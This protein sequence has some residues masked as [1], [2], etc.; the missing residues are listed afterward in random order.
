M[1]TAF[2]FPGQG[3][4]YV[5]MGL[6]W[7]RASSEAR[8][9]CDRADASLSYALTELCFSGPETQLNQTE[10]T[11]PALFVIALAMWQAAKPILPPPAFVVG[12]S[13]GEF[14]ALVAAGALDFDA[15]LHLVAERGRLMARAGEK[16][17]GGMAVLL[18]ATL[19]AA[20]SLCDA[21][22]T[23][24]G[25]P[26]V[27]AN[28]NCP[29]QVVISGGLAALDAAATLAAEHGVRRI[30][31]LAVS[32]AP[33]SIL[34]HE[35]QAEFAGLLSVVPLSAPRIPIVLNATA[36]PVSSPE[37]IRQALLC[38]LTS[39]VR[40][41]ESLLW[42]AAQGVDHFVEVGPKDVLSGMVRWTVPDARAEALEALVP[43]V[44]LD[45]EA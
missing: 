26:L 44:A 37:E 12:H 19:A 32:V 27:I 1:S 30:Q 28:D 25:Q 10:F 23:A 15:G 34:M 20:E 11:Q 5:G 9:F 40:W 42:V 3:S 2:L 33:H 13:L 38:Q 29:G 14:S 4:Q 39:P 24:S 45:A 43:C 18:G 16:T 31:R 17:P 36:A 35:V 8:L 22:T 6:A 41:R 7:Y 21:A